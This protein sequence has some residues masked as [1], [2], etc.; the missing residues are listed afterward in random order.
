MSICRM[1]FVTANWSRIAMKHDNLGFNRLFC[2]VPST[3][4]LKSAPTVF[5]H[6]TEGVIAFNYN[7][8]Y[9]TFITS[10]HKPTYF[11]HINIPKYVQNPQHQAKYL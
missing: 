10:Q 3:E 1:I 2:C 5:V 11:T 7:S 4:I 6:L 8:K 9:H